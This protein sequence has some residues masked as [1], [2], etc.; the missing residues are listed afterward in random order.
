MSKERITYNKEKQRV[1]RITDMDL[2]I[3]FPQSFIELENIFM[4]IE[5]E[6]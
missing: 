2:C 4:F 5:L 1:L 3:Y 6:V